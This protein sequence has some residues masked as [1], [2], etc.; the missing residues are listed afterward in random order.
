MSAAAL[1]IVLIPLLMRWTYRLANRP[2]EVQNKYLPSP[3]LRALYPGGLIMFGWGTAFESTNVFASGGRW[4]WGDVLGL[5]LGLGFLVM[6]ILSWP[7]TVEV[8]SD[9]LTW[10][11]LIRRHSVG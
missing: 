11:H 1:A 5:I 4:N 9:K 3:P 10:H 2:S 6:T 8:S 7:V